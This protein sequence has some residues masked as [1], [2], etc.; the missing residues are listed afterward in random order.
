MNKNKFPNA[1]CKFHIQMHGKNLPFKNF[2]FPFMSTAAIYH[3][4]HSKSKF[5]LASIFYLHPL[6]FLGTDSLYKIRKK[7]EQ[8]A[9]IVLYNMLIRSICPM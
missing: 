7:G 5:S 2:R 6:S 9:F 4:L 8:V 3:V 1:R